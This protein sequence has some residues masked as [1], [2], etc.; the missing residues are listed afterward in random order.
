MPTRAWQ[1]PYDTWQCCHYRTGP[2]RLT[3]DRMSN[4]DTL[5]ERNTQFARTDA[6][7]RGPQIPF[8]PNRQT[9]V[10]T[11][12]DPRVDPS[13]LFGLDLGD[14]IVSRNV[15]GRVT[16]AML[17]DVAWISYLHEVKT[18]DAEWFDIVVM[19]HTDCGSGLFADADLRRGFAAR[20]FADSDLDRLPVLDP[21]ETVRED[22]AV[23]LAYPN[24]SANV[25]VAGWAYDVATGLVTAV[26]PPRSRGEVS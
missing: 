20:G 14:A 1:H 3:L 9:F 17:Q 26:T 5:L 13:E 22:V 12:I 8:I 11:C 16:P 23:L 4:L 24:L 10:I 19:H 6:K 2:A 7:D 15:G 18:P 21:T 25:R